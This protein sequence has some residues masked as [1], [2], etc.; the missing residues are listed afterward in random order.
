MQ[1]SL[2]SLMLLANQMNCGSNVF[3]YLVRS[4][5]DYMLFGK[6]A[7]PLG[8]GTPLEEVGH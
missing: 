5:G 3:K 1:L 4:V 6:V 7:E 8:G 2:M